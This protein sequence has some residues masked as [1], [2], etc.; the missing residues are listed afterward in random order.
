MLPH[1]TIFD[2]SKM[3]AEWKAIPRPPDR[4]GAQFVDELIG[5]YREIL[6]EEV[7]DV[8]AEEWD[9]RTTHEIVPGGAPR[10]TMT[11]LGPEPN[12][13]VEVVPTELGTSSSTEL[14]PARPPRKQQRSQRRPGQRRKRRA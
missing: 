8:A 2:F 4:E 6:T 14:Q 9:K 3:D 7:K 1:N 5:V 12:L 13:W 10:G 11:I